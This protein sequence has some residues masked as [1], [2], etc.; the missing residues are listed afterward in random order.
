MVLG[1]IWVSFFYCQKY[2]KTNG[3]GLRNNLW[4]ISICRI[5]HLVAIK[6]HL[7]CSMLRQ[8]NVGTIVATI[9]VCWKYNPRTHRQR[10]SRSVL[11]SWTL[12]HTLWSP[13]WLNF[14]TGKRGARIM[15]KGVQNNSN[16]KRY[17]WHFQNTTKPTVSALEKELFHFVSFLYH[18]PSRP[19]MWPNKECKN[20]MNRFHFN[21]ALNKVDIW[22][23]R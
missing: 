19:V 12:F 16:H 4:L 15:C 9:V 23:I 17:V 11:H 7:V 8:I 22:P 13:I 14:K 2:D 10:F 21:W 6:G 3:L 1:G 20:P 5:S 18:P